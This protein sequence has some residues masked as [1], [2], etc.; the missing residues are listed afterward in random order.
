[1]FK[2]LTEQPWVLFQEKGNL[3]MYKD[4]RNIIFK[5]ESGLLNKCTF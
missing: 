3:H 5:T 4:N 2:Q 1:M